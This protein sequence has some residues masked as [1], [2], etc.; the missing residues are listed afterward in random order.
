M[1]CR[2]SVPEGPATP[3]PC[4]ASEGT[5]A[6]RDARTAGTNP[7]KRPLASDRSRPTPEYRRIDVN[8][9]DP[10][11]RGRQHDPQGLHGKDR[12]QE[13]ARAAYDREADTLR[14]ELA[15]EA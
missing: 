7:M 9:V 5:R 15:N 11:Q 12:Q 8:L 13:T 14:D 1:A 4:C 2:T 3:L 6:T 10:R